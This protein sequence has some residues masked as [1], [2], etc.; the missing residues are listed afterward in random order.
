MGEPDINRDRLAQSFVELVKIDSLSKEE[1][2]L[3]RF[4]KSQLA[5]LGVE[6][7]VDGAGEV[8][9]SDTGNL[10]G[11]FKGN[12]GS[13][14]LLLSAHMDTV[15]PGIGV[16]PVFEEGIFRSS[17][18]TI[19]GADDK[20]GIAIILEA[21]RCIEEGNLPSGPLELVFSICEEI[22][23]QGAK[24]LA[25]DQLTARMGYVLDTRN[26]DVIITH[27][28]AA[29]RLRIQ[30]DGKS[31]HAGAEP[32]KGINAIAL[33]AKAIAPL[34]L[35]RIDDETTCNIGII[36]GG[37]ATNIVPAKVVIHGEVRSHDRSKLRAVT[38]TMVD[39]FTEV[40][41]EAESHGNNNLP[42]LSIGVELDFDL[43][44]TPDDHAV[45]KIARQAAANLNRSIYTAT[46]G[47][48]S[49]ANILA[50]H[51][52]VAGVLGTGCQKVH[53]VEEQV[54]LD[55][56]VRAARLL[57]EIIRLHAEK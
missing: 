15:A 47:G 3:C 52:I 45:V 12:R 10:I 41:E 2:R 54:A 20:A 26:P 48:G 31:A 44:S 27:A 22:G 46:S 18:D 5:D 28:P 34:K 35:G 23:L 13:Q 40:V 8:T 24:H 57:V 7:L 14:P 4:L 11:R 50:Q 42:T 36:E 49:D 33:A 19:L 25:Y 30:I 17:G 55:D 29:N 53:T 37:V 9:G 32:E 6:T 16:R 21:L 39:S 43:L 51:G 1:A 38:D 56:M